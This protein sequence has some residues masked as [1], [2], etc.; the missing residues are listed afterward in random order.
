M[1]SV[2]ITTTVV[3]LTSAHG[4]MYSIKHYVI[5]FVSDLQQVSGFLRF[6]PPIKL[7]TTFQ[8][9]WETDL[10]TKT[11]YFFLH[12][13]LCW[14]SNNYVSPS[15]TFIAGKTNTIL[16]SGWRLWEC[17]ECE[18][19]MMYWWT[20]FINIKT[21][22]FSFIVLHRSKIEKD[23]DISKKDLFYLHGMYS[24]QSYLFY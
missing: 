10:I 6:P 23:K 22:S 24:I 11:W 8:F 3:S 4:E 17:W 9:H 16:R 14:N 15:A 7:T 5:K 20:S 13:S 21:F 18:Y 2:P 12:S 1:Q 19:R